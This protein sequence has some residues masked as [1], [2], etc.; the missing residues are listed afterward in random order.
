MVPLLGLRHRVVG[1]AHT[2]THVG[3]KIEFMMCIY[4]LTAK[5]INHQWAGRTRRP[6]PK[7]N[8]TQ[9]NI[10]INKDNDAPQNWNPFRAQHDSTRLGIGHMLL[11]SFARVMALKC[12]P[13]RLS[14]PAAAPTHAPASATLQLQLPAGLVPATFSFPQLEFQSQSWPRLVSSLAFL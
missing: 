10:I 6:N 7:A 2:R 9:S 4:C 12:S 1:L 13:N 8:K 11:S 14:A 5:T 3:W